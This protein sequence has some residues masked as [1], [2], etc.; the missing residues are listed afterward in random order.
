MARITFERAKAKYV[1]RFTMEHVPSWARK[2]RPDGRYYA[3][4]YA[5]DAEWFALTLFPP[6]EMCYGTD[7]FS[8]GQTWPLG[9]CLNSPYVVSA[10]FPQERA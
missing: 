6:N 2:Q 4:Q 1:H 10:R 3:P 8:S 5:S 7:C 9:D